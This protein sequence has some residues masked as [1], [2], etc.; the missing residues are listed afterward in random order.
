MTLL[1][2]SAPFLFRGR[3]R[4]YGWVATLTWER[5]SANEGVSWCLAFVCACHRCRRCSS[6]TLREP[7]VEGQD[8][9]DEKS[10]SECERQAVSTGLLLPR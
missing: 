4:F 1:D 10:V 2:L 3:K 8:S 5:G 7:Y 6:A 9:I